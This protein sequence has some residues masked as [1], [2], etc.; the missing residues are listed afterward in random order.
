MSKKKSNL[1]IINIHYFSPSKEK[2]KRLSDN[3]PNSLRLISSVSA[4]FS[5]KSLP[6]IKSSLENELLELIK[7][8]F[9]LNKINKLSKYA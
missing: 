8:S 4:N 9:N 1:I 2:S 5:L 7:L 3:D 6:H